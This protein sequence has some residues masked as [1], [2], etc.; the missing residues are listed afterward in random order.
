LEARNGIE[1]RPESPYLRH[2]RVTGLAMY[3]KIYPNCSAP[4]MGRR[5]LPATQQSLQNSPR[6]NPERHMLPDSLEIFRWTI[7][8]MVRNP[9]HVCMTFP[10]CPS[11]YEIY[12]MHVSCFHWVYLCL[13][14]RSVGFPKS[15]LGRVYLGPL[16]IT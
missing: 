14:G 13:T 5:S 1:K 10:P 11:L 3:P 7:L 12:S 16:F 4:S 15:W 2:F 9:A 8:A 6:C